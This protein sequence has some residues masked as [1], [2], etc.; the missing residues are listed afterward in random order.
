MTR[1]AVVTATGRY[2]PEREVPN[3]WFCDE[4]GLE[5]SDAWIESR[6]GVQTRRFVDREAGEATASMATEAARRC[7]ASAGLTGADVDGILVAT[8]TPDHFFP[9]TACLVQ[10][11]LGAKGAYGWDTSAACSGYLFTLAQAAAMV[12]SGMANR[13]LVIGAD[14]MS[15]IIDFEDRATCVIFGDGAGCFLVE[16]RD[17]PA[18][19]ELLDFVMHTDGAGGDSLKMVAGGSRHPT[20]AQTVADNLHVVHQ[21]GRTVFKHAVGRMGDVVTE[22][23]ERNGLGSADVKLAIPHQANLRIIQ[24]IAKRQ[25]WSMDRIAVTIDRWANTT[26]ATLP[27]TLD[28]AVEEGR[29]DR[30][31]LVVFATFGAGFTWGA[32]L[33]RW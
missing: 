15:S 8:V 2:L 31:D 9:S 25:G 26:A 1:R 10:D 11:A 14:T 5:T 12:R 6:T 32:A 27:T 17:E 19:G 33:M 13:L 29:L 21:D 3:S 22:L 23:L 16:G 24:S 20:S 4:L 30:G 18:G 7:L 28:W